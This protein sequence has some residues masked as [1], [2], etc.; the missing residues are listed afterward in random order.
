MAQE[1]RCPCCGGEL[2]PG[3]IRCEGGKGSYWLPEGSELPGILLT[4]T[5]IRKADGRVLGQVSSRGFICLEDPEALL[6]KACGVLILPAE[7]VRGA[8][9]EI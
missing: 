6:C 4:K 3:R 9:P 1:W 7:S 2:A 8:A 5:G